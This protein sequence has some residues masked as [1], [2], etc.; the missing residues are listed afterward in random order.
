MNK[1]TTRPRAARAPAALLV[2]APFV[3]TGVGGAEGVVD[4]LAVLDGASVLGGGRELSG[5]LMMP[6]SVVWAGGD[7]V[8]GAVVRVVGL[9]GGMEPSGME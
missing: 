7:D 4:G 6:D 5:M 3:G 1:A 2:D 9:G 8:P